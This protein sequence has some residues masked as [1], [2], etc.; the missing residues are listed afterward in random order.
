M[1]TILYIILGII[2]ALLVLF[3]ASICGANEDKEA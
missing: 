1:S 3:I 2:Y